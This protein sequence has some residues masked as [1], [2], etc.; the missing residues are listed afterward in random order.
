MRAIKYKEL[1]QMYDKAG[2]A[3]TVRMLSEAMQAGD[4][5]PEDFSI[6]ETAEAFLGEARVRAMDSMRGG[7]FLLEA[8][9]DG[10]DVTAFSNIT[11]QLVITAIME[12]YQDESFVLS[13]L[14][15]TIP[16]RLDGE[17]IPGIGKL[18]D[19]A[20]VVQPGMPFEHAGVAEDY[21]ETPSTDKRGFIVPVT[22]EAIFFDRTN[23]LIDRCR[24]VGN[25]LGL[26]KEKRLL[27]VLIGHTNNYKWK[28]T[29]YDS[30]SVDGTTGDEAGTAIPS[31]INS[32]ASNP[33]VDWT[34][35][36]NAEQLFA[37]L[38]D[39]NTSEPIAIV[40]KHVMVCPAYSNVLKRILN[41][42]E[43][44]YG[45]PSSTSVQTLTKGGNLVPGTGLMGNPISGY[46]PFVSALMYRR[47]IA[48]VEATAGNA[49]KWWFL[50]DFSKAIAYMENWPIT[51]TQAPANSEA[52]FTQ[53]VV[54]RFK[55]SERGAAA[56]LDPRYIVKNYDS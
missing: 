14:V 48:T 38:L 42:T 12:A 26:N 13:G 46:T 11:G 41:A 44:V 2:P 23:L 33:L 56:M 25:S 8:G 36:D 20:Q 7:G 21:I 53:D 28:G 54:L 17:K 47:L 22:K 16:T 43:I 3:E 35:F 37:N 49:K 50:G 52:E 31:T 9:F 45:I 10:V 6:R 27:D 29:T 24:D 30:Y 51:V 40:P 55:C 4:L 32:L 1:K 18:G 39:P 5:K 34:D 15:R 19:K